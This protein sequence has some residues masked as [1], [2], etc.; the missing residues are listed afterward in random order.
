[1]REHRFIRKCV[2]TDPQMREYRF[3]HLSI[4]HLQLYACMHIY[5]SIFLSVYMLS[6]FYK[7]TCK[8]TSISLSHPKNSLESSGRRTRPLKTSRYQPRLTQMGENQ[9][10]LEFKVHGTNQTKEGIR[11]RNPAFKKPFGRQSI[12]IHP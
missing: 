6:I 4:Y 2:N 3:I 5:S 7:C 10:V 9:K 12:D 8:Y 1:M 11:V